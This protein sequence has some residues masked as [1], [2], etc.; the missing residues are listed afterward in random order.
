MPVAGGKQKKK[1]LKVK[2]HVISSIACERFE[3]LS[4][5][6]HSKYIVLIIVFP[7]RREGVC[8]NPAIDRGD[9]FLKSH[10]VIVW[11]LTLVP[12]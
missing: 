9:K 1:G 12:A 2:G 4:F 8:L 7:Q 6:F 5:S 11:A 3:K 10:A